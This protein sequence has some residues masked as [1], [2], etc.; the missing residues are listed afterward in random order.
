MT[1]EEIKIARIKKGLT[2]LDL[3]K[4]L[5]VKESTICRIETGRLEVGKKLNKL[6]EN[7]LLK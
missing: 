2:Q 7:V 3:A 6:I 5:G 4:I 1:A